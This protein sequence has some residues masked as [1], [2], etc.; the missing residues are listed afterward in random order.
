MTQIT[1]TGHWTDIDPVNHQLDVSNLL[2]LLW[3]ANT[4]ELFYQCSII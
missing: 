3:T 1:N 2:N 4:Y